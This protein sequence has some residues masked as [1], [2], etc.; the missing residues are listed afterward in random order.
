MQKN[1]PIAPQFVVPDANL[2]ILEQQDT[3]FYY[4]YCL[5]NPH[6]HIKLNE[7]MPDASKYI[8]ETWVYIVDTLPEQ[9]KQRFEFEETLSVPIGPDSLMDEIG[10]YAQQLNV[11]I[12]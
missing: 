8:D 2:I 3:Q 9:Q 1:W 5:Q 11:H 4:V 7:E 10:E 6:P 12:C